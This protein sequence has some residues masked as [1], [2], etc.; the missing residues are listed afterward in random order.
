MI[1]YVSANAPMTDKLTSTEVG[2]VAAFL[3]SPLAS[4]IT[5]TT[6]YVDKGYHVMGMGVPPAE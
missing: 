5:G 4:G 6:V 2:N 3:S 1:E